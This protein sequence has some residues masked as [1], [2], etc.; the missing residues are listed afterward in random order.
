MLSGIPGL[1][2]KRV[3]ALLAT[4]SIASLVGLTPAALGELVVGGK[5]LG[6][7]LGA[8]IAEALQARLV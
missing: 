1:G 7:K 2:A 3:E 8:T 5:R 4:H 6:P